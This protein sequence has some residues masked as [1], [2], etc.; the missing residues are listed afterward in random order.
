MHLLLLLK[1]A[2]TVPAEPLR[3]FVARCGYEKKIRSE[4]RASIEA[5]QGNLLERGQ[6]C[7]NP[8]TSKPISRG[9]ARLKTECVHHLL[10]RTTALCPDNLRSSVDCNVSAAAAALIVRDDAMDHL[11]VMVEIDKLSDTRGNQFVSTTNDHR[12]LSTT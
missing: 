9:A 5:S 10:Q 8:Y 3:S 7:R 2:N 12:H 1:V 6:S 4:M 11:F